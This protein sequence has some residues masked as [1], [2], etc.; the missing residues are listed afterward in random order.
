MPRLFKWILVGVVVILV[1]LAGLTAAVWVSSRDTPKGAL[2]TELSGVT[3]TT[4]SVTPRRDRAGESAR[5][6]KIQKTTYRK[7][8][9]CDATQVEPG[10]E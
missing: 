2:D 7:P 6:T 1:V 4:A 5:T 3:V 8:P 9:A 10:P